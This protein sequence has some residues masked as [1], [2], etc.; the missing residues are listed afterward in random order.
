V[1][2]ER[3]LEPESGPAEVFTGDARVAPVAG[4]RGPSRAVVSLVRFSS[5]ARTVW[6]SHP[7][8][9]T[10]FVVEGVGLVQSRGHAVTVI[11]SGDVVYT[12]PNEEHWHGA[13]PTSS[14]VHLSITDRSDDGTRALTGS[15][16]PVTEAEYHAEAAE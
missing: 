7:R 13:T 9:Q 12:P 14:M 10:L 16:R 8:G 4:H 5:K 2:V 15:L 1:E 11:R 6:H 3:H